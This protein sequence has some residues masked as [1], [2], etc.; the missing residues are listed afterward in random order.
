MYLPYKLYEIYLQP[1]TNQEAQVPTPTTTRT[2]DLSAGPVVVRD[3]GGDGEPILLVHGLLVD[4][5]LWDAVAPRLTAAG[6]RVVM[7]DLPLGAHKTAM[8][9]DAPLAPMDVARLLGEI[10][11]QLELQ[12]VTLVGNDTGGAICQMAAAARPDWLA[13]LVLT[14]CD[15]Y[16]NFLPPLFAPL[17]T[18]ARRA[19][20]LLTAVMQPMRLRVMRNSPLFAG[21]LTK[22]GVDSQLSADLIAPF[23][24]DAGV[25]RDTY[26]VLAGI[27][28]ADTIRAAKE[29]GS[30]DRPALVI[31]AP[32]DRFFK[33]RFAERLAGDIPGARIERI[34]D[35][36]AFTPIDQPERTAELIIDLVRA[37]PAE[38]DTGAAATAGA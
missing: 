26:K 28:K 23:M 2:L 14:P 13:R 35:S 31:W 8:R 17:A 30:F 16:E 32:E 24:R 3:S 15:A 5:R 27:D 20:A 29:L 22:R 34:D 9:P 4:G 37:T 18:L 6:L 21:W 12:G 10:A 38:R 33:Q 11:E 25:R 7:P 19:P 1:Q 36:Y